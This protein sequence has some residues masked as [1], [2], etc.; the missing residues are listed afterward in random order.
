MKNFNE[1]KED[2]NIID[3]IDNDETY[4]E[5]LLLCLKNKFEKIAK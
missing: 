3:Y 2:S 1:F 4:T 5:A